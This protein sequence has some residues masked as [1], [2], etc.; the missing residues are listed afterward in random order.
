MFQLPS[1]LSIFQFAGMFERLK[2]VILY[3]LEIND[4]LEDEIS[5]SDSSKNDNANSVTISE[6]K[7]AILIAGI[8]ASV[9]LHVF[10]GCYD[11]IPS[12]A[13]FTHNCPKIDRVLVK[14]ILPIKYLQ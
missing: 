3:A 1:E 10:N 4:R 7:S 12:M 6:Q 11:V 14:I 5:F 2:L 13:S 9:C 8:V